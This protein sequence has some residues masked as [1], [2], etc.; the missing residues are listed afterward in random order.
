MSHRYMTHESI[1]GRS[2]CDY[3]GHTL[4]VFDLIPGLSYILLKGQ[5]RY[6]HHKLNKS[7]LVH[8]LTAGF[9]FIL[10]YIHDGLSILYLSHIASLT[11]FY[12]ISIIDLHIYEIPDIYLLIS[13]LCSFKTIYLKESLILLLLYYLFIYF[14]K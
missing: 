6:C 12:I 3:C 13:L 7:L 14:I 2:H 11:C 1:L 5:C 10:F 8:E 9:L 4:H